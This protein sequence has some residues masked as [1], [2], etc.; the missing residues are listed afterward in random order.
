MHIF[1]AK[2]TIGGQ[3]SYYFKYIQSKIGIKRKLRYQYKGYVYCH[4]H[5]DFVNYLLDF[6]DSHPEYLR[7]LKTRG[8]PE[9]FFFQ[10]IIMNSAFRNSVISDPLTLD[11]WHSGRGGYPAVLDYSDISNSSNSDHIF[12]RKIRNVDLI[13]YIIKSLLYEK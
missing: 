12:A 1:N 13:H 8:I 6:W 4:L 5:K 10:N 7:D 3:L 9:E 2:D 11:D